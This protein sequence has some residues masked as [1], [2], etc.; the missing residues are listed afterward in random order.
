MRSPGSEPATGQSPVTPGETIL[1]VD[2][3][4]AVS[5]M[6]RT[7]V[8]ADHQ[9][10]V[11]ADAMQVMTLLHTHPVGVLLCSEHLGGQETGLYLLS[12]VRERFPMIQLVLISEGIDESLLALAINEVGVLKYLKKPLAPEPVEWAVDD[13]IR[14]YRQAIE[15]DQLR[16][17]YQQM[18]REMRGLPYRMRQFR[19]I[20]R[21]IMLNG[22]DV[23]L[24]SAT[25]LVALQM[26]F[27]GIGMI[28]LAALYAVK[29]ALGIDILTNQHV[30]DLLLR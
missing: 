20:A 17:R 23:V 5:D 26:V 16:N 4:P 3:D 8:A 28:V 21:L 19:R 11:T 1:L 14:H 18:A 13:A 29:S 9:L 25:T 15:I 7:L 22:R 6:L 27:L 12:R 24:A 10:I 2:N 30:E